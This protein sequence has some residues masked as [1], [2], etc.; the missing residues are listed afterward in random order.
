MHQNLNIAFLVDTAISQ[1]SILNSIK[2]N[3]AGKI[4]V[5]IF[6]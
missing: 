3:G 2:I 1:T 6:N 4:F 5:L